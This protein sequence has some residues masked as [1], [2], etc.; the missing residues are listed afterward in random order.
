MTD[1]P[2]PLLPVREDWT[3]AVAVVAHPDDLEYG[4]AAA[5]A[6]WTSQ[7]KS[8]SYALATSGEAG[9]DAV[10]PE[11]CGPLREAEERASA[12]V[13]GVESVEFLGFPD[14]M[15]EYGLPLRR[16][17]AAVIRRLRPEVVITGNFRDT[18][19][20]AA[21]NQADHIATGRAVLDAARDAG[22][23]WVFR[24]LLDEGLEPWSG[25]RAVLACGSPTGA[26]GVDTTGF[27][28]AGIASL[29][30]HQAYIDGLNHPEFDPAEFLEGVA[31]QCGT[32]LGTAYGASFEVFP[33]GDF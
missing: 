32:R 19:D 22:N 9:I 28:D 16:A 18:W 15:L 13:V 14:G 1:L 5:I 33:L 23:R 20:G 17:I 25:V 8:I 12:R 10:A 24:E 11:L 31:R 4:A 6:R 27:L 2:T 29:L 30:E 3:S 21:L 7:G 26:H